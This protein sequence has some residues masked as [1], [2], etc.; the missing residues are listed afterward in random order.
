MRRNR[1]KGIEKPAVFT[2]FKV[3]DKHFL[4]CSNKG[5]GQLVQR[6]LIG[7]VKSA[8]LKLDHLVLLAQQLRF[9]Q[10][11]NL[12][13]EAIMAELSDLRVAAIVTDAFEESELPGPLAA[14]QKAGARVEI[15]SPKAGTVRAF[16][17]HEKGKAI[18]VD[19]LLHNAR[20]E[21]Y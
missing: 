15:I 2:D 18:P 16:R 8:G 17:H 19:V 12:N 1:D 6:A 13:E 10:Q 5:Q 4:S 9:G 7:E 20:P 21:D 3:E 14:L 11:R